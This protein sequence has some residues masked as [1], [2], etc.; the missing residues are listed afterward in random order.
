MARPWLKVGA[1][2]WGRREAGAGART[3]A[4]A[5]GGAGAG[6]GRIRTRG[7]ARVRARTRAGVGAK[8]AR[9]KRAGA[10]VFLG[11]WLLK[12]LLGDQKKGAKS[13]SG[14]RNAFTNV[15]FPSDSNMLPATQGIA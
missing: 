12:S 14:S 13:N 7:R 5:E 8:P 9:S 10:L 2:P 6:P 15:L 1:K 3:G 4:R 11:A